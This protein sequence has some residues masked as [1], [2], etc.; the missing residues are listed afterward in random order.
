MLVFGFLLLDADGTPFSLPPLH[1]PKSF[2]YVLRSRWQFLFGCRN[3]WW[4]G[5]VGWF[6]VQGVDDFAGTRVVETCAGLVLDGIGVVLQVVDVLL[7]A[8]IFYLQLL[9]LPLQFLVF[10]TLLFIRGNAIAAYHDVVS[11]KDGERYGGGCGDAP[12]HAVGET[13]GTDEVRVLDG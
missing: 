6:V 1:N 11:E 9:D 13:C 12:T 8:V 4:R 3:G 7:H 10:K 2:D 5:F